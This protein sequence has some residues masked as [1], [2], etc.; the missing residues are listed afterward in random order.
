MQNV[1]QILYH[2]KFALSRLAT[3]VLA[4]IGLIYWRNLGLPFTGLEIT[5][6]FYQA[7]TY[8]SYIFNKWTVISL[9]KMYHIQYRL[10]LSS[11]NQRIY[12]ICTIDLKLDSIYT[13]TFFFKL[14]LK[15]QSCQHQFL[16]VSSTGYDSPKVTNI[17][18]YIFVFRFI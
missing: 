14:S 4:S 15:W 6:T 9:P 10:P 12:L 5:Q 1:G 11:M 17:W 18:L 3:I 2:N 16:Q 13:S 8:Y 7:V